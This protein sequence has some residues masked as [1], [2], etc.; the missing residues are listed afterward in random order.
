MK[1]LFVLFLLSSAT[2]SIKAQEVD[3]KMKLPLNQPYKSSVTRKMDVDG[4]QSMIMDM[5]T[6]STITATKLEGVN[7]TFEN[8]VDAVKVDMDAGMMTVSY[9]SENPSEDPTSAMMGAQFEKMIGKKMI[10]VTSD[11]GKLISSEGIEGIENAFD[12]MGMT[13]TYPDKAVK[14]GD[15]WPSEVETNGIKTQATNKFVGKTDEGYQVESVGEM[16]DTSDTKIGN[17][18]ATYIVD[19]QT[20]FT[21]SANIKMDVEV[22]GQKVVTDMVMTVT[23]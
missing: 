16:K 12:N 17:F 10:M 23:K 14:P 5:A 2:L 3:F 18:S 11:K 9:D 15:T 1:K 22:E 21:K 19:P 4:Q 8:T 20:F 13:A 7:Y 6:K